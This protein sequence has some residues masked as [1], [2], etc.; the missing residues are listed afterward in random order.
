MNINNILKNWNINYNSITPITKSS[1]NI[2]DKYILKTINDFSNIDN[3]KK[4]I[5]L[6]NL[7]IKH[8][9]PVAELILTKTEQY[10]SPDCLYI[11][12]TKLSGK[13]IDLYE[14]PDIAFE[15]GRELARLHNVLSQIEATIKA[16]D[17]DLLKSWNDWIK[18]GL[19]GLVTNEIIDD[20]DRTLNNISPK[21]PKQLIHRDFHSQNIL[22]KNGKVSGWLD[23]E[24]CEY[25]FRVFDMA[26]L[27]AGLLI[28]RY[29]D[30]EKI[31]V[32]KTINEKL[33]SGYNEIN[34]LSDDERNSLPIIMIAIEL[35]FVSFW[36][37]HKN[38]EQQNKAL[39]LAVWLYNEDKKE[40]LKMKIT[41]RKYPTIRDF[42]EDYYK[43][44]NFI[45][46][47]GTR[48]YNKN[49]HWGRWEWMIGHTYLEVDTLSC[50]TIYEYENEIIG[51]VTHDMQTIDTYIICNPAFS[52][53]KEQMFIYAINQEHF[54]NLAIDENDEELVKL[55]LSHGLAINDDYTEYT[56]SLDCSNGKFNYD[57]PE[58]YTISDVSI[59]NDLKKWNRAIWK[60][61]DHE[62]EPPADI[63][64]KPNENLKLA[65]FVV[66]PNGDYA[67]HCQTWYEPGTLTAYVEPLVTIPEHRNKGLG[68]IA[69][70]ESINR[71]I[72][73]GAKSATVISND[74][75]YHKIGFKQFSVHRM[76][77]KKTKE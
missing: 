72:E 7:L 57:L 61:F 14:E 2:D 16:K 51:I 12:M 69:V 34:P 75:F 32:W 29:D 5:G 11:L 24:I 62:G 39:D 31:K 43:V 74:M 6:S 13:H 4:S 65:V 15:M 35:L 23:F 9:I 41:Q 46:E 67:S 76:W 64:P 38:P 42:N 47:H 10:T 55:A 77:Q 48:G 58:G 26:Y 68:K 3:L 20:I 25:N 19:N 53:I 28:D 71:C 36:G 30:N 63:I 37:Y 44:L 50:I 60:G 56:L 1:W 33:L 49:Y 52:Y 8:N 73:M 17:N 45:K 27:L 21:L 54:E 18:K 40:E 59:D 70:Y 66:A 22:F